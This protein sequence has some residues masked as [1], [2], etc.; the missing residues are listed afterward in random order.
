MRIQPDQTT[1]RQT[2]E[3]GVAALCGFAGLNLDRDQANRLL[4][5][6]VRYPNLQ[7]GE[8]AAILYRFPVGV[9]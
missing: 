9:W 6:W 3:Q 4:R 8:I 7:P 2:V 1:S 5:W